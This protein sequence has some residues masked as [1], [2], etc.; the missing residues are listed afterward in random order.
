[1]TATNAAKLCDE[2]GFWWVLE[3]GGTAVKWFVVAADGGRYRLPLS[4]DEE[5]KEHCLNS[6]VM[7]AILQHG[8]AEQIIVHDDVT[9]R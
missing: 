2:R 4:M 6:D 9:W 7:V 3:H 5:L 8:K 1:M